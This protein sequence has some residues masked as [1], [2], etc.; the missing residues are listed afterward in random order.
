[1]TA[2]RI[3][4]C[5]QDFARGGTERIAIGLAQSWAQAGRD[6]TI[7]YGS[8]DGGLRDTVDPRVKLMALEPPV[9]RTMLSRLGL[10]KAMAPQVAALKPNAIFLPGNHHLPLA[11][12]LRRAAP[13]AM[14]VMKVSNPPLPAGLAR[15]FIG[16]LFR[17]FAKSVDGFA[18]LSSAFAQEIE[19]LM[20]GKP[21]R[22]L[23]DPIYLRSAA[24]LAIPP[25]SGVCNILWAG[26]LEP[27]KDVGLALQTLKAL[28]IPAHLTLLGDGLLRDWT[29]RKIA[30]L[31]LQDRV[32]RVG[33]VPA[34]DP[35]LAAADMLLLTSR[36]EG[37]PA[38]VG[39]ALAHGVPVVTTDCSAMLRDMIAIPAAG[40]VVASHDP[41]DLAAAVAQVAA[42]PRLPRELVALVARFE[43]AR[44]AAAYLDWFDAP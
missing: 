8:A 17:H 13:N 19:S 14:I 1:M 18:A 9:P 5:L 2:Q 32:T 40:R 25:R 6:V 21:V 29:D 10:G 42:A 30:R 20:P 28:A 23:H 33:A 44:C 11:A 39:E 24:N 34:I 36:Y 4:I 26:R 22:V 12:A 31:G 43:P 15:A 16:P 7:L 41:R 35:Y 38:V 27:Q 37:Q 3:L